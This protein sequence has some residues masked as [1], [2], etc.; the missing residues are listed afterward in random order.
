MRQT[1]TLTIASLLSIVLATLHITDDALHARNGVAPMGVSIILVILLVMLYGT[2]ELA[3]RR[4]GYILMLLGGAGAAAMPYLHGVGPGAT[5]WGFF[6]VWTLFALG[7][8]GS[9]TA[10]L[11]A[12]ALWRSFR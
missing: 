9:F 12:R 4:P 10:I 8:T 6:F 11:S 5:R 3:G 1:P 7:V 2:T